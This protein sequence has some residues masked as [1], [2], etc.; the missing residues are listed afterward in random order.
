MDPCPSPGHGCPQILPAGDILV[1]AG[2]V[3]PITLKARNLPQPQS[4][5]KNY[6]CVFHIQGRV[7][8]IPAVRF[9]SSCIQCQNT[10]SSS[11]ESKVCAE[12]EVWAS[13]TA[14]F[15]APPPQCVSLNKM[16]TLQ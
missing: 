3:R 2:M 10:S 14:L 11:G 4:G 5:Q 15:S 7:Q 16:L 13:S 6:E 9:N 12:R 1:A 8:R